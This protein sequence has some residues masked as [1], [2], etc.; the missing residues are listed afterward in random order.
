MEDHDKPAKCPD[1]TCGKMAP[2]AVPD[3]VGGVFK[4][5]GDGSPLPQ[6]T[7]LSKDVDTDRVIG[8]SAEQGWEA[9]KARDEEKRRIAT[10][11]G[12][13]GADLS[14]KPDRS[15]YNVLKPEE[16][17]VHERALDIHGKAMKKREEVLGDKKKKPTGVQ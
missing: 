8:E 5:G 13:G 15:G 12:V 1:S 6:N 7:G 16:K 3:D 17:G 4:Q 11:E 14:M 9:Q 10:E 2:R